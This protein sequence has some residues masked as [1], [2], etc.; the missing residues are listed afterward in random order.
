MSGN[1]VGIQGLGAA[2]QMAGAATGV[3]DGLGGP[4][5]LVGRVAGLGTDELEAGIP[6]WAWFAIGA[7]VGA[8]ATYH[9]RSNIEHV[10]G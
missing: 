5:G 6:G 4:M 3:L 7:L 1:L 8:A 10:V 9:F 2:Q